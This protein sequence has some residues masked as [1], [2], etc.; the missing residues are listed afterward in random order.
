MKKGRNV[1]IKG[2]NKSLETDTKKKEICKIPEKIKWPS[3]RG[4]MNS[5]KWWVNELEFQ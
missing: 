2:T 4:S 5:E 3:K 1:P